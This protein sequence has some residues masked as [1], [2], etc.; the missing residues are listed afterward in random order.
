MRA[1]FTTF[2]H[3]MA[4]FIAVIALAWSSLF[5]PLLGGPLHPYEARAID[6]GWQSL[7]SGQAASLDEA[8]EIA[9]SFPVEAVFP[10]AHAEEMPLQLVAAAAPLELLGG[11][12]TILPAAP[13][14]LMAPIRAPTVTAVA[15][16]PM[17]EIEPIAELA[18]E[19]PGACEAASLASVETLEPA[20]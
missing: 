16:T 12:D 14:R 7:R 18:C 11:P 17:A 19:K 9:T 4:T 15:Y 1:I 20:T 3:F 10:S 13:P 2:D 6:A 5:L 8:F